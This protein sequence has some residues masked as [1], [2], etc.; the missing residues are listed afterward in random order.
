MRKSVF[1]VL[2]AVCG[3]LQ[4]AFAQ[5]AVP[6]AGMTISS[7]DYSGQEQGAYMTLENFSS[8]PV[9]LKSYKAQVME[10]PG[11]VNFD[12]VLTAGTTS[13]HAYLYFKVTSKA[14]FQELLRK[15]FCALEIQDVKINQQHFSS[16]GQITVE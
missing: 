12:P 1:I 9:I 13:G 5:Q 7:V 3:G 15:F 6:K 10:I 14:G 11:V 4:V 2:L 16:C 8:D